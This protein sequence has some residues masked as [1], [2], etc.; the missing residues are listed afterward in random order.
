MET[1]KSFIDKFDAIN[2]IIGQQ[3]NEGYLTLIDLCKANGGFFKTLPT[4]DK[5]P[6]TAYYEDSFTGN[7][8]ECTIYGF[9]YDGEKLF[10]CTDEQ[11][12]NYEYDTGYEF[13]MR[14]DCEDEDLEHMT[15]VVCDASY[16][17]AFDFYG[18]LRHDTLMS[19]LNGITMYL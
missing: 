18:L 8:K 15:K 7:V 3:V 5:C 9:H 10:V 11:V 13:S 16:Y 19:I 6:L 14:E 1:N 17:I 2:D 4:E 12:D